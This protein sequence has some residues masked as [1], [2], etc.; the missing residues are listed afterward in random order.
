[1]VD[2]ADHPHQP[3]RE[4]EVFVGFVINKSGVQTRRQR[5]SSVKLKEEFEHITAGI[6]REMRNPTAPAGGLFRELDALELCLAC[7]NV[8]CEREYRGL[9]PGRR[10]S[11]QDLESFKI[12]A[13]AAVMRELAI[14]ETRGHSLR[15]AGGR[16]VMFG[17]YFS[18]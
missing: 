14:H 15:N 1:M 7:L 11:S 6:T 12:V 9:R 3:L 16:G 2:N 8:G 17:Q 10:V 18:R 13:A 4:L 5:D